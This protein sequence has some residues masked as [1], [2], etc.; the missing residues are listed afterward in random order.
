MTD[1]KS[2][3]LSHLPIKFKYCS[4][5]AKATAGLA[6]RRQSKAIYSQIAK[7]EKIHKVGN[8]GFLRV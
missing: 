3:R 6:L 2:L 4:L 7:K 8:K 5:K 1:Y